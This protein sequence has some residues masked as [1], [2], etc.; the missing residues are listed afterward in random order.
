MAIKQIKIGES[1]YDIN[2]K[3]IASIDSTVREGSSYPVS[4][5]AVYDAIQFTIGGIT[6]SKT[7]QEF[8]FRKSPMTI[9]GNTLSLDRIKGKTLV[10][11]QLVENGYNIEF[12]IDN[13]DGSAPKYVPVSNGNLILKASII[14]GHRYF[15]KLIVTYDSGS[16]IY[17]YYYWTQ[18]QS[19]GWYSFD[20]IPKIF[21]SA[22][23]VNIN[24]PLF[25]YGLPAGKHIKGTMTM[26]VIDLTLMFG[27]GHEPSTVEE[28]EALYPG[29]YY[30]YNDGAP[31]SNSAAGL[32]TVG[33]NQ[34]VEQP[35]NLVKTNYY[36]PALD[37]S[38]F[39]LVI[40]GVDYYLGHGALSVSNWRHVYVA[41]DLNGNAITSNLFTNISAGSPY[42]NY[43]GGFWIEGANNTISAITMR[44]AKT[45][46]VLFGFGL[47]SITSSTPIPLTCFN[48]SDTA[49]NGAYEPYKESVLPLNLSTLTGKKNGTGTSEVIFPD[50]L[51]SAGS[52]CDEIVGSKAIRR[53]GKVDMGTLTWTTAS[54]G[55]GGTVYRMVASLAGASLGSSSTISPVLCQKYVADAPD[56]VY[57]A[58][59]DKIVALQT[60]AA[61]IQIIDKSYTDA[62]TFKTAMS[63]VYL[64]YELATPEEFVLDTPLVLSMP[65]GTTEQRL[66]EDTASSVLAPFC[67]DITYSTN[68]ATTAGAES[69][70]FATAAGKLYNSRK[71][72]GQ[73]FDGT[74]DITGALSGVTNLN[75]IL[76][77][78]D[79]N[80]GIGNTS[81]SHKLDVTG[82]IH[83]TTGI[84][85]DGYVTAGAAASSSDEAF[86]D[87]ITGVVDGMS[88]ISKLIP[89]EWIWNEKSA[90][91]GLKGAG[92]VAQ[93]VSSVLTFAVVKNGQHLALNYDTFHAYEIAALQELNARIK[94]LERE[95]RELKSKLNLS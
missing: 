81:P 51:R 93:E 8:T 90:F 73:D 46:Y 89:R 49:K 57:A 56:E 22:A 5:G 54:S 23:S 37:K 61:G 7:E 79:G 87:R 38:R 67:A 2:D 58:T 19:S 30:A 80:V 64:Y 9:K 25:V 74:V 27:E 53:I 14:E 21:T 28:F 41:Y 39:T 12:D 66:P 92:L 32:K 77:I 76:H 29:S 84:V 6:E 44:F 82:V 17:N 4:G 1:T 36:I 85:S 69:S 35:Q 33:F 86:K 55:Q 20:L 70:L 47:G 94:S 68:G 50:G 16:D 3:R 34:M 42:Y 31:I 88:V 10:W 43:N 18:L 75:E 48:V 59:K 63:G 45:C 40:G 13:T 26:F 71:I 78:S 52:V 65:S 95:N 24:Q 72:W 62:A 60:S 15:K 83:A 91:N 11:N